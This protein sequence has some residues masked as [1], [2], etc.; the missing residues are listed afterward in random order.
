MK[1]YAITHSKTDRFIIASL[2][3][4]GSLVYLQGCCK[5]AHYS[6]TTTPTKSA[7]SLNYTQHKI[8]DYWKSLKRINS[9][10]QRSNLVVIVYRFSERHETENAFHRNMGHTK[11]M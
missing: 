11:Q 7:S 6:K 1:T 5:Q 2:F 4:R 9:Q 3:L 10:K 8:L